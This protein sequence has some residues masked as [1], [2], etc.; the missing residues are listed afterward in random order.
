MSRFLNLFL[1]AYIKFFCFHSV[2]VYSPFVYERL[3]SVPSVDP[4]V[5][6]LDVDPLSVYPVTEEPVLS[7]PDDEVLPAEV[8]ADEV[9]DVAAGVSVYFIKNIHYV[10]NV[11][12]RCVRRAGNSS[13]RR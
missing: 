10:I 13:F 4:P 11:L 9:E 5:D 2:I 1:L 8:V 12:T 7:V 3:V 6:P